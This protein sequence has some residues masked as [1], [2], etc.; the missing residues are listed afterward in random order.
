MKI[1]LSIPHETNKSVMKETPLPS[2]GGFYSKL[3]QCNLSD[4][5]FKFAYDVFKEENCKN[6]ED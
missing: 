5:D 4:E 2:I 1:F 3:K 6:C